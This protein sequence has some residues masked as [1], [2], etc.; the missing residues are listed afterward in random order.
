MEEVSHSAWAL[1][2]WEV[3]LNI[4]IVYLLPVLKPVI[5]VLGL[6]YLL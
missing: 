5:E 2:L 6:K 3:D 1:D 4:F